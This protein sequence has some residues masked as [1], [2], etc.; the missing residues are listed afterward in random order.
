MD[1][2]AV[3]LNEALADRQAET[4]SL[5]FGG[6]KRPENVFQSFLGHANPRV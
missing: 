3:C 6:E 1:F 4:H 5:R 2:A